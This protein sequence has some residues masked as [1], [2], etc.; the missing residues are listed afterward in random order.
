MT[1]S[2]HLDRDVAAIPDVDE[3]VNAP[4]I[5]KRSVD[6]ISEQGDTTRY[7]QFSSGPQ[8]QLLWSSWNVRDLPLSELLIVP[9]PPDCGE[10]PGL[11]G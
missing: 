10:T 7:Q 3:Q 1:D 2:L 9:Y 6:L 8:G 5:G 11:A 4:V